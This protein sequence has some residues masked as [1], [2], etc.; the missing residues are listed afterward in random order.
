[1]D[2][3]KGILYF[4]TRSQ[5]NH[6]FPFKIFRYSSHLLKQSLHMHDYVQLAYVRKGMCH[7]RMMSKS[8]TVSQGE[9]FIITPGTEHS[10]S[11]IEEKDFELVLIDF[12]PSVL[13]GL[14]GPMKDALEPYLT[15]GGASA[16]HSWLHVGKTKQTLVLQLLQE[17]Q[18]EYEAKEPGFEYSIRLSLVKLL[19][20]VEREYRK[21]GRRPPNRMA[22][23]AD[24]QPIEEV[25][26][27]IHDNYSQDIPLEHG[28][29]LANMAPAYFSHVF[30]KETGQSFIDYVNEVRIERAMELIRRDSLTITQIGFQV[31]YRHLSHFIRTFKKRTGITPTEYKKTFGSLTPSN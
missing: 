14:L 17:M 19:M 31:G 10:F 1:M 6:E 25:R 28:A 20:V 23:A 18:E 2:E 15:P 30:K 7:H 29:Y 24:R 13:D 27:Y 12:A 9:L 4:Q 16:A 21:I 11:A 8:L 3:K 5:L 26:R 22:A